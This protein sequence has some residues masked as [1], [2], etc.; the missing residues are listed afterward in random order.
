MTYGDKILTFAHAGG[1][2]TAPENSLKAFK[3][4][5]ELKADFIELDVKV[6]KDGEIVIFH[7]P[8][9]VNITGVV[10][11]LKDMTLKELKLLD[12][13]EGEKIPTFREVVELADHKVSLLLHIAAANTEKQII[14]ILREYDY[15]ETTIVSCMIHKYLVKFRELEPKLKLAALENLH[16]DELPKWNIRKKLIDN[17]AKKNFFAIN[18]EYHLVDNQF[19]IYAHQKNLKVFPWTVNDKNAIQTLINYRI[20]GIITDDI[21]L[22]NIL[23]GR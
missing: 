6:S 8:D 2:K 10:G 9:T 23:L 11:L 4:A 21:P 14:N 17:A 5:I 7:D 16:Y 13:G 20:N 1:K 18:P 3:K 22:I 12:V 19:V 15:I